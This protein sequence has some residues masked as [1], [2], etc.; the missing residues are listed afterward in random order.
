MSE[1]PDPEFNTN[2]EFWNDAPETDRAGELVLSFFL[3]CLT[4]VVMTLA[5]V[6]FVYGAP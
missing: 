6:I 2:D 4:G 3:G 1:S 5:V